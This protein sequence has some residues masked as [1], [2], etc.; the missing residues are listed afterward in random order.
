VANSTPPSEVVR[1]LKIREL[2]SGSINLNSGQT[3]ANTVDRVLS[4]IGKSIL[5]RYPSVAAIAVASSTLP[6][7][8]AANE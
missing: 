8:S 3:W 7:K 5:A 4:S 2:E 1:L 6:L